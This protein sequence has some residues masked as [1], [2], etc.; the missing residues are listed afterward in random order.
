MQ[1][2]ST[3]GLVLLALRGIEPKSAAPEL[4]TLGDCKEGVASY[5]L[6]A[7]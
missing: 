6:E 4:H 3:S 7:D 5:I 2:F 1:T